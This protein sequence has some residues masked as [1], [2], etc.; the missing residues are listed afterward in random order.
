MM[1]KCIHIFV[2]NVWL[3]NII[4]CILNA[5]KKLKGHSHHVW[6]SW[7]LGVLHFRVPG[8]WYERADPHRLTGVSRP[9]HDGR[10]SF[11]RLLRE[12][13]VLRCCRRRPGFSRCKLLGAETVTTATREWIVSCSLV[14][15]TAQT[16]GGIASKKG[17][18]SW[19]PTKACQ[20]TT[21]I[22]S[23]LKQIR[24]LK[25]KKNY[26]PGLF[27]FSLA[28]TKDVCVFS[29]TYIFWNR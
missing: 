10:R 3:W 20:R 5:F 17:F 4:S 24:Q 13:K 23:A 7:P 2:S 6:D 27:Y 16:H 26:Y 8:K 25:Y 14:W 19:A 22:K 18:L 12:T 11:L 29:C 1:L 9:E 15:L 21:V 28:H